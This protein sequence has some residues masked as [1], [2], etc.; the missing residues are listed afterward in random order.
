MRKLTSFLFISLDGVV[1]SPSDWLPV[2][3]FRWI[4]NRTV[5][6]PT[7]QGPKPLV[8]Q[9]GQ[10]MYRLQ[11]Q[12]FPARKNGARAD[13]V[14]IVVPRFPTQLSRQQE[15]LLNQLVAT[16]DTLAA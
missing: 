15:Q 11:G 5:D 1:E 4:A 12:G 8:L 9:R 16:T 2:D 14:V 7:L 10:V 3:G 6:A 13:Q